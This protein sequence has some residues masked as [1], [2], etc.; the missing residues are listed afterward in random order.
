VKYLL[1]TSAAVAHVRGEPGHAGVQA[2]FED[3]AVTVLLAAPS[4]LEM[5]TILKARMT[6]EGQRRAVLGLYG[7]RLAE[8]VPVDREAV[9]AAI[10]LRN[11]TPTR[12]PAVDA[13]IAGC[14]VAHGATLVHRDPHFDSIPPALLPTLRL[15]D[16]PEPPAASA[17]PPAVREQ[18]TPYASPKRSP[19][20]QST[21]RR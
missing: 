10:V 7:G 18:R 16:Q 14:A 15:S 12:L 9:M 3:P 4:L 11:G 1:D 6:D 5:E 8:V 2:L 20:R 13:L 17:I 19:R 21:P